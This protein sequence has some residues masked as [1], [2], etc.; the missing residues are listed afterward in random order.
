MFVSGVVSLVCGFAAS[1]AEASGF[2]SCPRLFWR[3]CRWG[4][5]SLGLL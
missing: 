4:T 1:H 5:T 3:L 2:P